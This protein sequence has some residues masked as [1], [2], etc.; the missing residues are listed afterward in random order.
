[1]TSLDSKTYPKEIAVVAF[2]LLVIFLVKR[3]IVKS[4]AKTRARR[5]KQKP[6]DIPDWVFKK[7]K[8]KYLP[9][10]AVAAWEPGCGYQ[11]Y[12]GKLLK[13]IGAGNGQILAIFLAEAVLIAAMGGLLGL[14]LGWTGIRVLT[15]VY[16]AFPATTPLWAVAA[17][18][19]TSVCMGALFGVLPAR[20]AARLDP[21][22][23]LVG[24]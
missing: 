15:L 9:N 20:R 23:A 24:K 1:M 21:V 12:Y 18:L 6:P 22:A 4:Y 8:I 17:A 5:G 11:T 14:A 19:A 2:L 13:A 16:P 10:G 7:G 3:E